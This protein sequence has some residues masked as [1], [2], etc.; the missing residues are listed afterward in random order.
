[1][2]I[3]ATYVLIKRRGL[4]LNLAMEIYSKMLFT[5]KT[6]KQGLLYNYYTS[7]SCYVDLAVDISK[8]SQFDKIKEILKLASAVLAD[9]LDFG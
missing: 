4:C 2:S 7:M 1:M 5:K 6:K 8:L 9:S 3:A